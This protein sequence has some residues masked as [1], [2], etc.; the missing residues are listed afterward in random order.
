M[1]RW[2]GWGDDSVTSE[3]SEAA[4]AFMRDKVGAA[5]PPMDAT[6]EIQLKA[7]P[8]S[9]LPQDDAW[10]TEPDSRLRHA[11]GQSFHDW[12]ELRAGQVDSFPD[13]VALPKSAEEVRKLLAKARQLGAAVIPYG[14]GTSVVGHLT[15]EADGRPVLCMDLSELN[16][17]THLDESSRLATFG[18]GVPG[19]QLEAQ[20]RERGYVLGHFPQSFEYSTLGGW[21]VT[22]SSGQQSLRYGRIEQMFAGGRLILPNGDDWRIPTIP[23]TGAGPDVREMVL[24]SEGRIGV[25]TDATVRVKPLPARE[26][27]IGVFFPHWEAASA[28]A[29]EIVQ[30]GIPLSMLR[31]SNAEETA[32]HLQLAGES[33]AQAVLEKY[34]DLRRLSDG[35][36]MMML[37]TTGS[38]A[39]VRRMR[40]DALSLCRSHNGVAVG[41]GIG[42]IWASRRYHGVY[43]RNTLWEAG[44]ALDTAETCV[45]WPQV[46]PLMHAVSAAAKSALA[47]HGEQAHCF[48]HLSHLY[49]QGSSVYSTFLFRVGKTP[50]ETLARWRSLKAAVSAAIVAHGGTISHQHGVGVDHKPYLATEKGGEIGVNAIRNMTEYF[51]PDGMMNP[52]KLV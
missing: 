28:A 20:L 23:A 42:K 50:E 9:R 30:A 5:T 47:E 18:A 40:G 3:V 22:R 8:D 38:V 33:R 11:R 34:L 44:F 32:S 6:F 13:A 35:R 1:R 46:T 41:K 26:D 7:V 52:G 37:G 51:D 15:P 21:I 49:S 36:C 27:F 14:G 16:Q 4:L 2:N 48:A 24:G 43:L 39:E 19:P 10:S 31:V 29:R 25:L 12:V 17:L 45:D